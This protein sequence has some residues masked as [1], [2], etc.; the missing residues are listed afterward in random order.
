[1]V[2]PLGAGCPHAGSASPPPVERGCCEETGWGAV[3]STGLFPSPALPFLRPVP[4]EGRSLPAPTPSPEP[5]FLL[6][7]QASACWTPPR[8]PPGPP[9]TCSQAGWEP[10]ACLLCSLVHSGPWQGQHP[11][12]GEGGHAAGL[13]RAWVGRRGDLLCP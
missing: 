4:F 2:Q 9:A 12:G 5:S 13:A 6:P 10:L 7:L 3:D 1:M 8:E 11:V